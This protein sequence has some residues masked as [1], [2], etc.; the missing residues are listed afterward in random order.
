MLHEHDDV[1]LAIKEFEKK[2]KDKTNNKW[3]ERAN[4]K[5]KGKY[6]MVLMDSPDSRDEDGST[7][8]TLDGDGHH[9][10][11][12]ER[13]RDE[14]GTPPTLDDDGHH[15]EM[16]ERVAALYSDDAK[17]QLSAAVWF[18]KILT[19]HTTGE[20]STSATS[21]WA[22]VV[23]SPG[24]GVVPRLVELMGSS[25]DSK[26]QYEA[27]RVL[28]HIASG[29]HHG[30]WE[31]VTYR[32]AVPCFVKLLMKSPS[33]DVR[34]QAAWSLGD[35]AAESVG[36]RDAVLEAQALMPLLSLLT[37]SSRLSTLRRATLAVSNLCRGKPPPPFH[38]VIPAVPCLAKLL[39]W[40]KDEALLVDA[41]WALSN[42]TD[43]TNE[44][45]QMATS[46]GVVPRVVELL[47]H[48]SPK[49]RTPALRTVGNIV[50]GDDQHVQQVLD[51]GAHGG[52]GLTRLQAA[53]RRLALARSLLS[54][55]PTDSVMELLVLD[56][57]EKVA[58]NVEG[59]DTAL[60]L[61]LGLL[62][63]SDAIRK[64]ACWCLSN[65]TA[66]NVDHIQVFD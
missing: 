47:G 40:T 43:G 52:T 32:G 59:K 42:L 25:V 46:A 26:L 57:V 37:E 9:P 10:E 54:G 33:D 17:A 6:N 66:S 14:D 58:G 65:I 35:I 64:E 13:S 23:P 31:H 1:N 49:V 12:R 5:Q 50:T 61:L 56:L 3:S 60:R 16:P 51:V 63:D 55:A 53:Q 20:W 45:I 28:A 34:G 27:A 2:F 8:L 11:L 36:N 48:P 44:K 38:T 15:Q 7:P 24:G 19:V 18:R 22:K 41:C 30:S 4:F 62:D 39:H 29:D 21:F